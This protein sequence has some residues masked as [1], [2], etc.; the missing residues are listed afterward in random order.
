MRGIN[1]KVGVLYDYLTV[2]GGAEK[3]FEEFMNIPFDTRGI[4]DFISAEYGRVGAL[5]PVAVL[6]QAKVAKQ[7]NHFLTPYRFL[8]MSAP[9]LL[10]DINIFSGIYAPLAVNK[11]KDS[12]NLYYCHTPPRHL[13]DLKEYYG[14]TVRAEAKVAMAFQS[15]FYKPLFENALS[16]MHQVIANSKT[17]QKRLK[18]FLALDSIVIYPPCSVE[19]YAYAKSENYYLSTARLEEYKRVDMII[20][21]FE[22]MPEKKLVVM[23]GGS[24]LDYLRHQVMVKNISNV[25]FTGWVSEQ[26][27]CKLVNECLA[28][29]YIPKNED[30]GISPVESMAAGKPVIGVDEGGVSETILNETTGILCPP[31]PTVESIVSAVKRMDLEF[32]KDMRKECEL[33]SKMFSSELFHRETKALIDDINN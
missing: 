33:R 8:R 13:Y 11:A 2:T 21:A 23:S 5:N 31:D 28:T 24:K 30:F 32:A 25:T 4:V 20:N 3:V 26:E 15:M 27:K 14:K 6:S 9:D 7:S 1:P 10:N 12:Y 29:I 16:K 22:K 18:T 19:N 17:V